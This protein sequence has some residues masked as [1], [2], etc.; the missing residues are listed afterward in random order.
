M[1][2]GHL[3]YHEKGREQFVHERVYFI[4]NPSLGMQFLPIV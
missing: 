1:Q 4:K 3:P 2:K